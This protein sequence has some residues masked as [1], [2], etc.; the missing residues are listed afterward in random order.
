[1]KP[2]LRILDTGLRPAR[3]NV[4][5]TAAMTAALAELQ[6]GDRS[7]ARAQDTTTLTTAPFLGKR[8]LCKPRITGVRHEPAFG[9]IVRFHRYPACVLL[10]ASQDVASS[11]DAA[12]C[13]KAGIEVVRRVTGGGAVY[14]S[15]G[16]LAWD[17]L[18]DRRGFGRDLLVVTE[19]VLGGVA[20]G[21]SRLGV[22]A[23]VRAPNDIAIGGRKV[24]GSSGYAAGDAAVL[25]GT[26]LI[27][28]DVP[29]MARALRLPEAELVRRVTCLEAETGAPPALQVVVDCI[30]MGLAEALGREPM[31][32]QPRGHELALGEALLRAEIGTAL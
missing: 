3:W 11:A 22:S 5:M 14:M 7:H 24:S 29:V 31:P 21:L 12:Y 6:A 28:D 17:V 25:Q 23:R 2:P 1:M 4:A 32:S 8:D 16:M 15:P 10:G 30:T 9:D 20:A 26:V 13:R 18:V 27:C 19:R